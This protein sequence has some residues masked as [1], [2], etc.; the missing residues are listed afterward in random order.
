VSHESLLIA[1]LEQLDMLAVTM[2]L[3]VLAP[4]LT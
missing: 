4:S 1:F 2:K 3:P